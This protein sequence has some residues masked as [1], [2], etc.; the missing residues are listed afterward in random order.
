MK[1]CNMMN[2]FHNFHVHSDIKI[3]TNFNFNECS[4]SIN[5]IT[6]RTTQITFCDIWPKQA[7]LDRSAFL[8]LTCI[9]EV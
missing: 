3:D 9:V 4:Y 5:E 2:S 7:K 6:Q 8:L 1:S